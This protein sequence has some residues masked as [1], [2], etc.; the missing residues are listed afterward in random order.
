MK[1]FI[2]CLLL[3]AGMAGCAASA[4]VRTETDVDKVAAIER[5]ALHSGVQ[6]IWINRPTRAAR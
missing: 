4:G 6:V 2:L 1:R 3:G 5:A